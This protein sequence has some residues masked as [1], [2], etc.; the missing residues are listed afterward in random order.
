MCTH[1]LNSHFKCSFN[2]ILEKKQ[3]NFSLWSPSFV[4]VHEV[5]IEVPLFRETSFA[6]KNSWLCACNFKL[7]TFI[8]CLETLVSAEEDIY[9]FYL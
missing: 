6:L 8:I 2:N 3:E 9:H 1:G 4:I 5:F 7:S